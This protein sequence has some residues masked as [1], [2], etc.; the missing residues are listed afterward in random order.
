MDIIYLTLQLF[1]LES[2]AVKP[3]VPLALQIARYLAVLASA[4]AIVVTMLDL[5]SVQMQRTWVRLFGGHVVVCGLGRKGVRMVEQLRAQ[6]T[7]VIVVEPDEQNVQIEHCRQLGCYVIVGNSDDE[8]VLRQTYLHHAHAL[9]AL[10]GDDGINVETAVRAHA[11]AQDRQGA[12]L[13]CIIHVADPHLQ[14]TLKRHDVYKSDDDPFDLEFYNAFEMGARQMLRASRAGDTAALAKAGRVQYLLV[15]LGQFGEALLTRILKD[16]CIEPPPAGSGLQITIIDLE[17]EARR[18]RFEQLF[19]NVPADVSID[20]RQCDIHDPRLEDSAYWQSSPKTDRL[21]AVFVCMDDDT[22]AAYAALALRSGLPATT[23]IFVRMSQ[24]AGLASLL[25]TNTAIG[26]I[27]NVMAVGLLD[28]ACSLDLVLG[29]TREI[30]AQ[31]FHQG[32]VID[33]L[34]AGQTPE[35]NKSLVPWHHLPEDLKASNRDEAD[36]VRTKLATIGCELV[37]KPYGMVELIAFTDEEVELLSELEHQRYLDER[38]A[39]GW[40]WGPV[41]DN[42]KRTNPSLVPWEELSEDFKGYN[43]DAVR[44]IP[45]VLA[46]ADFEIRRVAADFS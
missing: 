39:A 46:K 25:G 24:E 4:Y 34:A 14:A 26:V 35:E 41:R 27:P 6:R 9:I 40:T 12:H 19:P 42:E 45:K 17:A 33:Q 21:D 7:R 43:R 37:A 23:P 10:A 29:G 32:Y 30:L 8:W 13:R 1:T 38:A 11:L 22:S 15:G 3:P 31:A 44:R 2:G 16:W 20:F 36:H 18:V 28:I 5:F